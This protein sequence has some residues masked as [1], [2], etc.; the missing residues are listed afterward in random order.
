M[1]KKHHRKKNSRKT[2]SP[3]E[4]VFLETNY[5]N[6]DNGE[7]A[8]TLNVSVYTVMSRAGKNGWYKTSGFMSFSRSRIA[9]EHNNADR[10]NTPEAFRKRV[11]TLRKQIVLDKS[12]IRFGLGPKSNRHY[13]T[14]PKA[15]LLQRNRLQRL[16]YIV[17]EEKLV[18]Y[19]SENTRR[20]IRLEAVPRGVRKGSIKPY[21]SF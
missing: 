6:C 3:D 20:C 8:E 21:Y 2:F 4:L 14:E 7:L 13:R 18:A 16:G 9:R 11:E 17:D 19:Y 5:P 10:L 12:R 1:R 15:R